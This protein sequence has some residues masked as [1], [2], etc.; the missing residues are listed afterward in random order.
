MSRGSTLYPASRSEPLIAGP[1]R[2]HV[3]CVTLQREKRT[4]FG[5]QILHALIPPIEPLG[6]IEKTLRLRR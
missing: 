2:V 4:F 1:A 6:L 3:H 5:S